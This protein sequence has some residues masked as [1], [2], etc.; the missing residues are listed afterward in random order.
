MCSTDCFH[1]RQPSLSA[2][3][4]AIVCSASVF[5]FLVPQVLL[6]VAT[7]VLFAGAPAHETEIWPAGRVLTWAQPGQ[8]GDIGEAANW[9]EDGQA[10]E[11]APDN[12]C[13]VILPAADTL[14]TVSGGRNN[15]VRHVT[16]GKNAKL[17]GKHRNEVE[18]WGN[19]HVLPDGIVKYVS[20]VGEKHTFF[21]LDD[22]EFPTPEN[23]HA[24]QHPTR[25]LPEEQQSRTQISHK[26]QICKYGTASVEFYGNIGVGDEVM[27]QHG[28]MIISGDFR[29]SGVTNKGA[30]EIYDG[31]ILEL[32]SGGRI[33]PFIPENNKNVYNINIY[34]NGVIQAGS[35]ERPLTSDAFLLLGFG[36]NEH[37][38][39]T[40]LYTALGSMMRVY[41]ANPT[42]A[43]LVISA[44]ASVADFRDGVGKQVGEPSAKASGKLGIAMQLGGDVQLDG[45]HFDYVSEGGIALSN[46]DSRNSW[47]HVSYGSQCAGPA[48]A[49]F[50]KLAVD[51]NS[52]YHARNDQQSEFGLTERAMVSMK[53]YLEQADP[54]HLNTLPANTELKSI[55]KG[56]KAIDTPVA[57]LFEQPIE[58]TIENSVPGARI[59]FTTDGSEPTKDSPIYEGPIALNKT[60]KLTIK[61]YKTGVG[62]SP[63]YSTTYVFK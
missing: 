38:G 17:S 44:T 11:I 61:A 55:G 6:L 10:A 51:P 56:D 1:V 50:S 29:F 19:C 3:R 59:R 21:R 42:S 27:L 37:P 36:D 12:T 32:Q 4:V 58:V 57:V 41:S 53:A 8:S 49:L 60:T 24:Y 25:R 26:F 39:H 40:G 35:P 14:Y 47:N 63:T 18:I 7:P 20:V 5:L 62:F 34:R 45:V 23:K 30:F 52:Y 46:P 13:D 15:Q 48:D 16:V 33:G 54:F 28:K 2:L 43:R 31:G 9:L 22:G